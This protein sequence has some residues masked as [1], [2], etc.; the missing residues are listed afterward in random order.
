MLEQQLER[1]V[2]WT[3]AHEYLYLNN[4]LL[5]LSGQP[6]KFIMKDEANEFINDFLMVHRNPRDSWQSKAFQ[7]TVVARN[8]IPM[9]RIAKS[10]PKAAGAPTWGYTHSRVN[11]SADIEKIAGLLLQSAVLS[12]KPGR[13][14]TGPEGSRVA[15]EESIAALDIG[16]DIVRDGRVLREIIAQRTQPKFADISESLGGVDHQEWLQSMAQEYEEEAQ[17]LGVQM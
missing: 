5:N 9:S 1:R 2:A 11:D 4:C 10:V 17:E 15:V 12:R 7:G 3:D 6:D 16:S 13:S 14:T 8:V